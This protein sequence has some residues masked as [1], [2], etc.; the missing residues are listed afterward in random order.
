MKIFSIIQALVMMLLGGVVLSSCTVESGAQDNPASPDVQAKSTP[1]TF[2]AKGTGDITVNI[3]ITL[4]NPITYTKNGGP[5]TAITATTS[6]PVAEG[7]EVCFFSKNSA[8]ASGYRNCVRF[9]TTADCDIYGNVMSLIDDEGNGF[10]NDVTIGMP[11]A[12]LNLFTEAEKINIH[13][14]RKLLL[15]ATTLADSCYSSM[16]NCCTSL[17]TAP[18]LPA[19]TLKKYCYGFMFWGCTSLSAQAILPAMTLAEYC[20]HCMFKNCT[21]LTTAPVL[22]APTL[23]A[24]CYN[25]MFD[26][27]TSLNYV[28]C[29]ATDVS[30]EDCT[31]FWLFDV[32][33][34]GTFVK[35]AGMEAW[36]SNWS[37]IPSGWTITDGTE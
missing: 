5:A 19:T 35:A 18:E 15:P 6:I 12:L 26:E 10:E 7:D 31:D 34:E 27:C 20:Y 13:S 3:S 23:V 37:G 30:A 28:K 22:P 2:L 24:N 32:A 17:T 21:S 9:G 36:P 33:K 8:L 1:L 11:H 25:A 16:F 4:P 29:L 14:T